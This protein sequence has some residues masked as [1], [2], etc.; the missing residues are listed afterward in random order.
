ML[1]CL[2][3]RFTPISLVLGCVCLFLCS[4]VRADQ[5]SSTVDGVTLTMTF[6]S[7]TMTEGSTLPFSFTLT[8]NSGGTI[9]GP[10]SGGVIQDLI[11]G[12]DGFAELTPAGD[13]GDFTVSTFDLNG[14]FSTDCANSL[15][16]GQ[17]CSLSFLMISP[18]ASGTFNGFP[19]SLPDTF[20]NG[21]ENGDFATEHIQA[22]VHWYTNNGTIEHIADITGG[23]D[24]TVNDPPAT[25]TVPEP[26]PL[27]LLAIG[28]FGLGFLRRHFIG[29]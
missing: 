24:I 7:L 14:R 13:Q 5:I 12:L 17:S 3:F 6:S 1:S 29:A 20:D 25:A 9:T 26:S 28:L 2:Q 10:H 27:F 15:S 22:G 21:P 23:F 16:D 8:N 11:P 19:F 18:G 4:S